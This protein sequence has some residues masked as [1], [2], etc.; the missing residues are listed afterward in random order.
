MS[1]GLAQQLA[2]LPEYLSRHLVLSMTAIVAGV[3]LSIPLAILAL[4]IRR[5]QGPLL[6]IASVIQ[7]IPGLALL[8]L[9]VPLLRQIGFVPA[10]IALIL[11]S[12][13]PVLRNT[14]TGI[15]EIDDNLIEAGRGLGMTRNQL[16]LR[17]QLPLAMPVIVAGI[18]TAA[19]W[20]VGMATLSTPVGATSLGN[21]IFSGLQTQNYTAVLV[22]C[23]AAALLA[24]LLDRLIR[25][26]EVAIALRQ[27]R[28]IAATAVVTL[29][30]LAGGLAPIVYSGNG[31]Q[32]GDAI[33]IGTK[34][35]TEQYILGELITDNLREAGLATR[36][37]ESLGSTVAFDALAAGRI[38]A[39][40]DYTGTIWANYMRRNTNP[41]REQIATGVREWLIGEHGIEIAAS[42]G[43]E[44]TYAIAVRREFAS[45]R[46][47]RSID[48]LRTIAPQ[49]RLA[50]DY[51]FFGR[52]EWPALAT[53]YSLEF[54]ELISMDST[55]MYAAANAG[56]VDVI[57]AFSTDGRIAAFDLQILDDTRDALPPYDAVLLTSPGLRARSPEAFAVLS[58]FDG[59]ISV[60]AMQSANRL[61]DFDGGTVADGARLLA[62]EISHTRP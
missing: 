12:V 20:V 40:V 61:V 11:Y 29:G 36:T 57:T 62:A 55:L 8:A 58:A 53:Q 49:L 4:R 9:M 24:M 19:V 2:L 37:L 43:F 14:V 41:G 38:D 26:L 25:A 5:L 22:G 60:E 33:V 35:F 56:D 27:R 17:V 13:L 31:S 1:E 34:T 48:D 44:N 32:T 18:R 54:A 7:T 16:L 30:I 46:G 21:Y 6:A 39:Y 3:L 51:E 10:V 59:S 47:L 50:S 15:E 42:L 45:Q 28:R 23:V 52:P